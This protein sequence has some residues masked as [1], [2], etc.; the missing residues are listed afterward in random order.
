MSNEKFKNYRFTLTICFAT[1][2]LILSY[3]EAILPL[4]IGLLGVK[5]GLAN[6]ITILALK[7]LD[8]KSALLINVFRIIII[9]VLFNN[10][11][12][13]LLSVSGFI[14][15]FIVMCLMIKLYNF[16][17]IGIS[18][19]GGVSHNIGQILALSLIMKNANILRMIP[20]YVIIGIF[21]GAFVGIISTILYDRIIHI[22][23]LNNNT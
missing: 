22:I 15:S 6:I 19:F 12:R 23:N 16:S 11:V 7:V 1:I 13:F 4:N 17:I 3:V 20:I 5:I 21:T 10:F 2:S 9:A 14:L 8:V 18:I